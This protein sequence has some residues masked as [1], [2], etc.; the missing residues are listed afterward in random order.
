MNESNIGF[1]AAQGKES[2]IMK[3][4]Y[5]EGW[6]YFATDSKKI[7][8]D[9]NGTPK[10]PMGGNSGVYYGKLEHE[11]IIPEGQTE[12]EFTLYDIEGNDDP[13]RLNIPNK[14][15]LILNIP[16][17]CFYRVMSINGTGYDTIVATEKLT[18]AGG[19]G[20]GTDDPSDLGKY[21]L[22]ATTPKAITIL[23]G[24]EYSIGF[25]A[26]ASDSSGSPTGNGTYELYVQNIKVAQGIAKQ[27]SN[28]LPVTE[29]LALGDNT[30]KVIVYMDRGGSALVPKSLT[31]SITTTEMKLVW[32]YNESAVQYT[33]N[34]LKLEYTVGGVGIEKSVELII[35]GLYPLVLQ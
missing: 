29:Y 10:L 25:S 28:S 34:E 12:F 18:I 8:L 21:T 1:R 6:L 20:G 2:N 27:G 5:N 16:D 33:D 31:Y 13:S 4:E 15:D 9:A 30:I 26:E 32:D 14:D 7:Y 24:S 35:D 3:T 23:Y 19:G 22:T 17:G 11:D